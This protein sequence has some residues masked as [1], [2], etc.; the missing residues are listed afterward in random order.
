VENRKK[1]VKRAAAP[2]NFQIDLTFLTR[3][4]TSMELLHYIEH[5]FWCL[6]RWIRLKRE[7]GENPELPRS[8]K[9]ERTLRPKHWFSH[10]LGS[11]SK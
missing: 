1:A 7:S 2:F 6:I 8:G 10:G 4:L 9:Q 5:T 3:S 11:W